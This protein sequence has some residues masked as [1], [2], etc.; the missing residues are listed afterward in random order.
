MGYPPEAPA[1]KYIVLWDETSSGHS[2]QD[3]RPLSVSGLKWAPFALQ[4]ECPWCRVH[5]FMA[6]VSYK[7][8]VLLIF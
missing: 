6:S 7:L 3:K 1:T 8:A 4:A 5:E 2:R